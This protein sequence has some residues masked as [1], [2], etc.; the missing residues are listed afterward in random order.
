M[1]PQRP[2]QLVDR[3][4]AVGVWSLAA[5][6]LLFLLAPLVGLVLSSVPDGFGGL[7]HP[8]VW[9]ALRL[10]LLTTALTLAIVVV[11]GLPLAWLIART[12]SRPAAWAEAMAQ[13]PVVVPP[14]V[15]G[16]A[17]LLVFGRAGLLG[18]AL[19][20]FGIELPFTTA[21]VVMAQVFVS[22]PFFLQAAVA[23]FRGLDENLLVVARTLGSGPA[24]T[25]FRVALP[26]SVPGLLSGAAMSWARA[27]GEFGATLMFAGNAEGI[28]Q[29]L[30][31][32]VYSMLE[33]DLRAAQGLSLLMV[34]LAFV[35]LVGLRALQSRKR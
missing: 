26:L 7:G 3:L 9:P 30:P 33:V 11:T 18:G 31:L 15:A 12:S 21:A 27:L 22:A 16:V 6:L 35:L 34:V 1:R 24:R 4:W 19:S 13:L 32:A 23:A 14:A 17:M 25:F 5:L 29:T 20:A 2:A 8:G 28:T 10:S